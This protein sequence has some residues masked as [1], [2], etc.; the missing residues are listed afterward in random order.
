[1]KKAIV[2]GGTGM[3]GV[4]LIN[5]L[6]ENQAFSEIVSLVRR[7]SGIVHPKLNEHIIDFEKPEEWVNFVVGDVLFSTL[8]TTIAQAKTKVS[9]YKVDFEYQ[10]AVAEIAA[11]N[12]VSS[13]VLVSS[14]GA[15][16]KSSVFY[17]NMKGKLDDA[18]RALPFRVISIL[19]PGQLDGN[20]TENRMGEKM[21][22]SVV[23]ALNKLGILRKYHPIQAVDV[24]KAMIAASAKSVS[25]TYTLNEVHE[26]AR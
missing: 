12:G 5:L 20:R 13:Y 18:V 3:V 4:Q 14:A 25:G 2:I 16:S 23:Y 1:M 15:D 19:R 21:A 7:A 10:F 11:S 8:G 26:L 24:A 6:I 9:Q 17:S 22:L